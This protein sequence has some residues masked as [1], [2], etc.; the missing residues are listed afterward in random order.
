M[1][2]K[3]AIVVVTGASAGI[4]EATAVAFAQRGATGSCS[5]RAASTGWRSLAD[6]IERAGGSAL[7]L[8]STSR[9]PERWTACRR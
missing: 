4:G 2:L 7:A 1:D 9:D 3:Q 6:R 8:R 5:R